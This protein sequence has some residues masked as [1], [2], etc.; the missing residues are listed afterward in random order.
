MQLLPGE[1]EVHPLC[2]P[3]SASPTEAALWWDHSTRKTALRWGLLL[4]PCGQNQASLSLLQ[5]RAE[6][7]D[8]LVTED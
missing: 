3:A 5:R 4:P 7:A 6:C 2:T 8:P 1:S